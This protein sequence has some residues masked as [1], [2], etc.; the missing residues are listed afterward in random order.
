MAQR[1]SG[2]W[3]RSVTYDDAARG[4]LEEIRGISAASRAYF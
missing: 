3:R 4:F 1:N 2:R